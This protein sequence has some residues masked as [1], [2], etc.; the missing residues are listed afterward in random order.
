MKCSLCI[1]VVCVLAMLLALNYR[2]VAQ[3]E[4]FYTTTAFEEPTRSYTPYTGTIP[5]GPWGATPWAQQY[6]FPPPSC[7]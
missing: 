7:V 3:T 2:A 5:F 6:P 1:A 4:S